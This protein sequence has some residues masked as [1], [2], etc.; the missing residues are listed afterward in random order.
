MIEAEELQQR[1]VVVE[2]PH[3]VEDGLV[4][5]II[6]LAVDIAFFEATPGEPHAEAVG[7]VITAPF[8]V[9]SIVL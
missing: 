6:G 3:L 5:E 7:V 2:V 1:G 8:F 9:A 4:A